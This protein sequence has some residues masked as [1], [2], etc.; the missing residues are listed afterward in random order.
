M[1]GIDAVAARWLIAMT[2]W[3][4]PCVNAQLASSDPDWKELD[5]LAPPAVNFTQL[6]A[7]DGR[8]ADLQFGIDPASL[9]VDSDGV[10]RYVVVAQ[11]ASGARTVLYEGIRCNT[12]QVRTYARK[13][14]DEA[15]VTV[16]DGGWRLLRDGQRSAHALAAARQGLCFGNGT[17]RSVREIVQ[18]LKNPA[19][20]K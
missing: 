19:Y 13:N 3:I 8:S 11:S 14:S 6:I 16:R 15:W 2:V 10:V 18:A 9:S 4:A 17:P 12:G 7:I 5:S 1:H 20:D